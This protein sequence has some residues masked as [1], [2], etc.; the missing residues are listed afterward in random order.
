MAFKPRVG[1]LIEA[2]NLMETWRGP[3]PEKALQ[4][5]VSSAIFTSTLALSL[6]YLTDAPP[7]R[8]G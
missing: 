7:I 8:G 2:N 6:A 4:A 3:Y 1:L 5:L